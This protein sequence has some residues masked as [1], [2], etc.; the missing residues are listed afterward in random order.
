[1]K[2]NVDD[3]IYYEGRINEVI[4]QWPFRLGKVGSW[5]TE[6]VEGRGK[7]RDAFV[8]A[9]SDAMVHVKEQ[10]ARDTDMQTDVTDTLNTFWTLSLSFILYTI[11]KP[12]S[13]RYCR[14]SKYN[15]IFI[16]FY[17]LEKVRL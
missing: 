9:A 10:I 6:Y 13:I 3:F 14:N 15:R 12:T 7:I 4:R 2:I 8:E 11:I 16:Y 1:M 17:Y 5:G